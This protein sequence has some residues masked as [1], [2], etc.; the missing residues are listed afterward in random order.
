MS[1]SDEDENFPAFDFGHETDDPRIDPS[2]HL[3][4]RY[5]FYDT[6]RTWDDEGDPP[7]RSTLLLIE[8][9]NF[10]RVLE[11]RGHV[12]GERV[13]CK[14]SE[15]VSEWGRSLG[16]IFRVGPNRFG[17]LTDAFDRESELMEWLDDLRGTFD[18]PLDMEENRIFL[19]V[20]LGCVHNDAEPLSPDQLLVK[21]ENAL[22]AARE[23]DGS[24]AQIYED[25]AHESGENS[26]DL[27]S[28]LHDAIEK[29]QF[30]LFYQPLVSFEDGSL[31]GLE[32]LI[33]WNHPAEGYVSP[34]QFLPEAEKSG[35]ILFIGQW[36]IE[37]GIRECARFSDD[38]GDDFHL[39][40]NV[41]ARQFQDP[42]FVPKIEKQLSDHGVDPER[43][44]LEITEHTVASD[45]ELAMKKL[46][47][48]RDRGV[49]L[50]LDDFGTG[51]SSFQ[52]L[53]SFPLN[54]LK[55]DR[56]FVSAQP[57]NPRQKAMIDIMIAAADRLG[58]EVVG[59][60]IETPEQWDSL[61]E[62]GCDT[63]QGF[64]LTRPMPREELIRWME[65]YSVNRESPVS[66][67]PV[68]GRHLVIP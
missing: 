57:G 2:T 32:A 44:E 15:L 41:S 11:S 66:D 38:L 28:D 56:S 45:E 65:S 21:A 12:F 52:Y 67:G 4:N 29:N 68:K 49:R 14:V 31:K 37:Q 40:L 5:A 46:A 53:A 64:Y 54:T 7:R 16:D 9:D 55:I 58:L 43:L 59:E 42:Q 47:E 10:Q 60:G 8:I 25:G 35:L 1:S 61:A 39:S 33:R 20:N 13:I 6:I 26:F 50:A 34:G 27:N 19:R 63:A 18:D 30:E 51:Y 17:L 48:L 22:S 36:V 23:Q 24:A 3:P 62:S